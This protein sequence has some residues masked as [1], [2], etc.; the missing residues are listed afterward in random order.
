MNFNKKNI[1]KRTNNGR[2][3][4]LPPEVLPT[5]LVVLKE[6]ETMNRVSKYDTSYLTKDETGEG[7]G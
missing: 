7:W 6:P 4:N 3:G 5:V 2:V 1:T